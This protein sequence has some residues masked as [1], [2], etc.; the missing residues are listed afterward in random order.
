MARDE[1]MPEIAYPFAVVGAAAGWLSA[2]FLNN[3]LIDLSARRDSLL[4]ALCTT[5]IAA[6]VGANLTRRCVPAAVWVEPGAVWIRLALA[7]SVGGALAGMIVGGLG[8]LTPRGAFSGVIAGAIC[9]LAFLPVSALVLAAARRAYRARHG[10]I[11]AGSDRRAMWGIMAAALAA[12]TLVGALDWPAAAL[13]FAETPWVPLGM[14][15]AC[16]AGTFGLIAADAVALLRV[17]RL[18]RAAR[19]ME[20]RD[21]GEGPAEGDPA[22]AVD[23]GLGDGVLAQMHRGAAAYRD[24]S[25]AVA[26]VLGDPEQAVGE[27]RRALA[28]KAV[29]LALIG[30]ALAGHACAAQPSSIATYLDYEC[31][32][33][34]P[35][36]CTVATDA[37]SHSRQEL[38]DRAR[39]VE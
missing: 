5:V 7:Q 28:R 19:S 23:V 16:A 21:P 39:A 24:R 32:T 8:W 1:R 17:R 3:P 14:A 33:G 35:D 15:V 25:R 11:V 2:G 13:G 29:G 4:A 27:L 38:G 10:S 22:P 9:G 26:L 36:V 20:K 6:G 31:L 12:A 30:A 37:V 34:N 18:A